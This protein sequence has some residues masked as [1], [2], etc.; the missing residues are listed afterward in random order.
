MIALFFLA[1]MASAECKA[2]SD[3]LQAALVGNFDRIERIRPA[4]CMD[5]GA[6]VW[7]VSLS[8]GTSD[9]SDNFDQ[10]ISNLLLQFDTSR[11][12][13]A[14]AHLLR[15]VRRDE[16]AAF[17][18]LALLLGRLFPENPA[19]SLYWLN[20]GAAKGSATAKLILLI[21]GAESINDETAISAVAEY[22]ELVSSRQITDGT[23]SVLKHI[24]DY[25]THRARQLNIAV[26]RADIA[27]GFGTRCG[28]DINSLNDLMRSNGSKK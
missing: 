7:W 24:D 28:L 14:V 15:A 6:Y 20:Q 8:Y 25:M 22:F 4:F 18:K 2:W 17:H 10:E 5:E 21:K 11:N 27:D 19:I 1:A 3:H 13:L 12:A 16:C 9:H 26:K 23:Y